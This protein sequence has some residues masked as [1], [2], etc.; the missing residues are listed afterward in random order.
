[1]DPIEITYGTHPQMKGTV[2]KIYESG[3]WGFSGED[4]NRAFHRRNGEWIKEGYGAFTC[5]GT[6]KVYRVDDRKNGIWGNDT[7]VKPGDYVFVE[8]APGEG[9]LIRLGAWHMEHN[10]ES[11]VNPISRE[12]LMLLLGKE[13]RPAD[14]ITQDDINHLNI[15]WSPG[16]KVR[17]YLKFNGDWGMLAYN[18]EFDCPCIDFMDG[19]P[20]LIG[21]WELYEI[22]MGRKNGKRN[23]IMDDTQKYMTFDVER[24]DPDESLIGEP[25]FFKDETL[26]KPAGSLKEIG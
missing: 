23:K 21:D 15:M 18:E 10:E 25:S 24:E 1:M 4:G 13:A 12:G 2:T 16:K 9:K 11:E 14:L 22:K 7:L 5:V 20:L 17:D 19:T 6:P 8:D 26:W 3:G